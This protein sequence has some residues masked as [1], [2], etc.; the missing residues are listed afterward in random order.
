MKGTGRMKIG[1]YYYPEQW[2]RQQWERDF[3]N[4]AAMGL[5]IV[6]MAEFAWFEMEPSPGDIRLD[7]LEQCV[8][9]AAERQLEVILCTPTAAPPI[10]LACEHPETL[11]IE[12][13]FAKSFG[14]RRHYSPTSPALREATTRIVTA[15][16]ERFGSHEAVIGWQIDNEYC[17]PFSTNDHT[18]A[19]F[20]NWLQKKY[21]TIEK[22]NHAWGNQFWT[23]YYT[24]FAQIRL[25]AGRDPQ[26]ANPHHHLDASRFWSW[27]FADFNRLQARILKPRVGSRFITT[28]FMSLHPDVDPGDMAEDLNLFSWDSYPVTGWDRN[29]TDQT[30][31]LADPNAVSLVHDL[32]ACYN[33]RWALMELQPGQVNWSGVPVLL[34]P[35]AVRL[36]IWTAFAHGA[37]FVTT[38]RFRQPRFG[39]ELFHHGLVQPD[40]ITPS[41]GG[42][43]FA[44][45]VKEM[46]K[47]DASKIAPLAQDPLRPDETVGLLLDFEQMWYFMSLP[48]SKKWK[49]DVFLRQWYGA[50]A[51][52]GLKVRILLPNHPWPAGLKFI[53]AP[54]VQMIEDE[55]VRRFSD[56]ASAGGHLLLTC[57]TA[58][59]D[60]NG[61]L[62]E[63]PLA[64]PILPLIG[65]AITGYD[66]LPDDLLGKIEFGGK[67]FQWNVWGDL[68]SP[69]RDTEV[70]ARY[71]D[72]FYSG[73]AAITRHPYGRGTATYCGVFGQQD[74]ADALVQ[75]LSADIGLK[76]TPLPHRL[77]ILRRGGYM[78]ALNYSDS[79]APVPAPADAKF[80]LGGRSIEPAGVAVWE[81]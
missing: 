11:P 21:G 26:Y 25:P 45:C 61:Q 5:Q 60:R 12:N 13:G 9:M 77:Q 59:M 33:G 28:N 2:P 49:Q 63:G 48:Q 64:A 39:I 74:L 24:S 51:R 17:G 29:P 76:S 57:R 34:Y 73:T 70:L 19:A 35:G 42:Q 47:L 10:W 40:G 80:L 46:R 31:R 15:M 16:A 30:F 50:I 27:A 69:A 14:G 55:L 44:Q 36:W 52:L 18:H 62:W 56:F 68:L 20:Q 8:E 4:I 58:L 37:E 7:W 54:G 81:S 75:K 71:A 67:T 23:T 41:A 72:Q 3:D 53:I 79:P 66:G 78:I 43:Q 1:A 38:Y 32:M 22:L 65:A 6:H